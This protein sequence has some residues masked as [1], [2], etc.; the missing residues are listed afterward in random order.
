MQNRPVIALPSQ[1][2]FLYLTLKY[3]FFRLLNQKQEKHVGAER[4]DESP[5][6]RILAPCLQP[7]PAIT[8]QCSLLLLGVYY[9]VVLTRGQVFDRSSLADVRQGFRPILYV[10]SADGRE[11]KHYRYPERKLNIIFQFVSVIVCI[12]YYGD[13]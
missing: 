6:I 9:S 2:L 4:I 1:S 5:S 8:Q 13:T 7:S 10:L 3:T 11:M 12:L